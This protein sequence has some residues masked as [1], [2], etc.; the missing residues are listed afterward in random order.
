MDDFT[1]DVFLSHSSK[2]KPTV[3]ELAERLRRDEVRVWFDEWEIRPGDS[4]PAKIDAGLECCRVLVLCMSSHAFDSG[5]V[6]LEAYT[7]RFRDPLNEERRFIPLRLDDAP[8][9][10]SLAQISYIDWRDEDDREYQRLVS[11][12]G[13]DVPKAVCEIVFPR[14]QVDEGDFPFEYGSDLHWLW[15]WGYRLRVMLDDDLE[16]SEYT[17]M[18]FR[19]DRLARDAMMRFSVKHPHIIKQIDDFLGFTEERFSKFLQDDNDA[20]K[21]NFASAMDALCARIKTATR[22]IATNQRPC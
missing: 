5:W 10:G 6:Q 15:G 3:R 2:D 4:I 22:I 19:P 16:P 7:F 20:S 14:K 17:W 8:I 13:R 18:I 12:C 1:Y 11:A 9:K 21:D